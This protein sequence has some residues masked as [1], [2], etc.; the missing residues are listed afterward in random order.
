MHYQAPAPADQ[1]LTKHDLAKRLKVS[2]RTVDTYMRDGRLCFL[3]VGRTVRFSWPDV[4]A[5]L[6]AT[7]VH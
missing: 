7:R 2:A 6:A 4:L 3:K 1:L 5:K